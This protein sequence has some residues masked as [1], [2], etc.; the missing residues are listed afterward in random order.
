MPNG[1]TLLLAFRSPPPTDDSLVVDARGLAPRTEQLRVQTGSAPGARST[2]VAIRYAGRRVT[3][4]VQHGDSV[5]V[6]FDSTYAAA[7]FAFN[8]VEALLRSV[9]LR[10][11]F[12]VV[13]PLFSELDRAVEHDTITVL[14]PAPDDSTAGGPAERRAWRVRFADPV[15]VMTARVDAGT[16]TLA[17]REIVQRRSGIRFRYVATAASRP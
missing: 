8:E 3:G 13:V 12:Q 17:D 7:P 10:S 5:P 16:R 1:G 11:G 9:P 15:I 2:T 14:G 6:P 4:T